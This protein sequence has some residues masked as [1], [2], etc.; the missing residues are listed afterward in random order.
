[1]TPPPLLRADR[2]WRSLA[3]AQDAALQRD[4]PPAP[5]TRARRR[6]HVRPMAA[7]SFF[8]LGA[9]AAAVVLF[10][11]RAP[12]PIQLGQDSASARKIELARAD[13]MKA[14]PRG[15]SAKG[16]SAKGESDRLLIAD[17]HSDLPLQ[18]SD[19]SSLT[20]RAGSS[21]RMHRL[22]AGGAEVVLDSGRL[23]AHVIHSDQTLWLVH[24]GPY[25]V[26]VTGTR[27]AVV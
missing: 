14:D 7:A 25:R 18:F 9:A 13:V 6:W 19:G 12:T 1:M 15:E 20:F 17:T 4:P 27:F 10:L 21:G 26:R 5:R 2:L 22:G 8:T 23:E 11:H 24:A 3:Q 16:E